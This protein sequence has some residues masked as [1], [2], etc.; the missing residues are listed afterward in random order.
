M[1]ILQVAIPVPL[2]NPLFDYHPPLHASETQLQAGIRVR[3]PFGTQECVGMIVAIKTHSD[4]PELKTAYE[5]LDTVPLIPKPLLEMYAW[6]SQYY[7]YPLGQVIAATLPPKMMAGASTHIELPPDVLWC[8]TEEGR[9]HANNTFPAHQ[10]RFAILLDL[11]KN[12]P[13]GYDESTLALALSNPRPTL[14]ALQKR[15]W[16]APLPKQ[17]PSEIHPPLP[18]NHAQQHVVHTVCAHAQQFYPCLLDGVTG[19]G[20]TEVYLQLLQI[21]LHSGRQALVLVPEINLTPQMV[22][23]FQQRLP[24]ALVVLHSQLPDTTRLH[25][26]LAAR[27]GQATVI[28]GTRSAVW[29][30]L[31]KPALIIVDEEHDPAYKQQDSFRYSARDVAVWRARQAGIPVILG[32]ATPSLDSLYNTKQ[33]R[34]HYFHL[35]ERAG[36]A[37]HPSYRVIDMR[38]QPRHSPF[39]PELQKNIQYCLQEKQQVLLFYNRRG[40]APTFM[41]YSCGWIADCP[42]CDAHLVYHDN[43]RELRCHH[44]NYVQNVPIHCPQCQSHSLHPIGQGTEKLAEQLQQLF[45]HA[46]IA[47]I[48]S[49]TT[50]SYQEMNDLLTKI[51]AQEIDILLGTQML[52]KGHHFPA[53][54][55]VGIINADAGLFSIDF[56][57]TERM[58]QL[59]IQV[60]GRAGRE[61]LPGMVLIQTYHPEHPLLHCLIQQGYG[62][63]AES[64]LTERLNAQ[65]PPYC[66]LAL[67]RVG[68]KTL[69]LAIEFLNQA[70]YTAEQL[71]DFNSQIRL[72]GPVPAPMIKRKNRYHAQLLI[73]SS[74]RNLLQRFLPQWLSALQQKQRSVSTRW[75][76]DVDPLD[77]M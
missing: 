2:F 22:A 53:V 70:K 74:Q 10:Q 46:R 5:C 3:V 67:L 73:Q 16:I 62:A 48:D 6:A 29:I 63:F 25:A 30:P 69:E 23:R 68:A 7:C 54:T 14:R 21:V 61:A 33:Q 43:V 11:L 47:R 34:Y 59:L 41:C 39:S 17:S 24:L 20:K 26:W 57:A 66:R 13:I 56:R 58:A 40:Y 27:D 44:C 4:Y 60:A 65:L 35:P 18:L 49:D 64:A 77:L 36:N 9:K 45:P 71:P 55:L 75:S 72:L 42:R 50:P 8:L 12:I 31:A 15:G 1:P 51:H 32:S 38:Q 19:S 76:L 28:I 37:L 52:A